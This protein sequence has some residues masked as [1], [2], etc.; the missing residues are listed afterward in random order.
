MKTTQLRFFL[1]LLLSMSFFSFDNPSFKK[2]ITDTEF[3]YEFYTVLKR[4]VIKADREYYWFKA[5]AIHNTE[6]GLSGEVL[7]GEFEKFYLSNQLAEKGKFKKGLKAGLWK[8]WHINGTMASKV[9]YNNGQKSGTYYGYNPQGILVEKGKFKNNKKHGRWINYI[10]QDTLVFKKDKIVIKKPK[11]EKVYLGR[12]PKT[13]EQRLEERK[14][15]EAK[16]DQKRATS[17]LK[18]KT[19]TGKKDKKEKQ[20]KSNQEGEQKP[21]KEP[22]FKRLFSKKQKQSGKSS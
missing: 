4:P 6:F 19:N 11:A 15:R 13:K 17:E 2:K 5:G 1:F 7:D 8:T 10:S 18:E 14:I 12:P 3:R 22:F 20:I 9:F 16:R 21:E